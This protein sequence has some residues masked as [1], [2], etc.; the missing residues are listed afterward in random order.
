MA[1]MSSAWRFG[2]KVIGQKLATKTRLPVYRNVRTQLGGRMPGVLSGVYRPSASGRYNLREPTVGRIGATRNLSTMS[3]FERF[4]FKKK[5]FSERPI[6]VSLERSLKSPFALRSQLRNAKRVVIKLGSA[7]ITREDECGLALGR[8]ASIVEQVAELQNEGRECLMVTS[9]AVA[10]GKQKLAHEQTL[11]MSMRETL[12]QRDRQQSSAK[13]S[14]VIEPRAAAAVGQSG[15]MSLYDAMFSQYGVKI[16]QV[17]VTKPDFYNEET[18][19]HLASTVSELISLNIV[20]IINTNDAV[21]PPPLADEDLAGVISIKDNDSLAARLAAEV[22]ADLLI[23]MSD[24]D[25][26][27][28]CPPSEEGARLINT[29]SPQHAVSIQYGKKSRVGLGGMDS[30]V[31]S[32]CWALEKGI[33]VVICN[34]MAENAVRNIIAGRKLGTF[35]TDYKN[36]GVSIES[37]AEHARD[38]GR[39]LQSLTGHQRSDIIQNLAEMLLERQP[40][41]LKANAEDLKIL[42]E[43]STTKHGGVGPLRG[44]LT[45]TPAKLKSLSDGLKQ[46]A[47]SS[48]DIVG[49][50]MRR[51]LLATGLELTQV[52][53]PIGVLLVIFESRPDVLPQVAALAIASA[54]GLLLK[55]GKEA[56]HSNQI[57]MD[58]VR[59][60]LETAGVP[61]AVSLVSTREEISDLLTMDQYIDLVI[62]R[63]SGELVRSIQQQSRNIPVLGHAEGVCHVYVDS[64]ADPIRALKIV[65]DAKCDYPSACNA[66]ETLLIHED[67]LGN[68]G[69]NGTSSSG[70][71]FS[72]VCTMLKN[73]GVKIFAGPSLSKHLTFGPPPAKSLR[74]EYG[75]LE[76]TIEVV[77]G[78]DEAVEHI[79]RYGSSHTETIVTE[80]REKAERFLH[81]VDSACVFHNASTRF[82]DGYRFGLGA[83]VGISTGRI[84]ARGPVGVEGLLTSKWILRGSGDAA[85]DF[86][87]N[88]GK[89]FLHQSLPLDASSV[90]ERRPYAVTTDSDPRAN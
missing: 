71:F 88:C 74:T 25:G 14:F 77:K 41:I 44:R 55:G 70:T 72:E 54:N 53:V 90:P 15:L 27:Y 3:N 43:T 35:F 21:S 23:L 2:D 33:S 40:Q 22:Q 8:L 46:I 50:I 58:V 78:L 69:G 48:H 7:V 26:I 16:A 11:S 64:E 62:P 67:L 17:L 86:A 60:A 39:Q 10:F 89:S 56:T 61:Q 82:A 32:A 4:P 13:T 49:R 80:N 52:T 9:G 66:M 34:G 5:S 1:S 47:D 84:H 87:P 37:A 79:H 83:E 31:R 42:N 85:S 51:T 18:R 73:E 6:H 59:Q 68:T 24:V 29:Y 30:K 28:T 63:G 57:L 65:R 81:A 76:C 36:G 75:S 19:R 20:P 38:G 45:L 12:H